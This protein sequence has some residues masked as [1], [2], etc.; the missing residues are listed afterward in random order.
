MGLTLEA[1]TTEDSTESCF[2]HLSNGGGGNCF[3]TGPVDMGNV[4]PG[5]GERWLM[6]LWIL[7]TGDSVDGDTRALGCVHTCVAA[8]GLGF[9]VQRW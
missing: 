8:R 6:S 2:L 7:R 3:Q 4:G 1:V 9:W 5:E